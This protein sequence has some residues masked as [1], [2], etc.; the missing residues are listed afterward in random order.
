MRYQVSQPYKTIGKVM[1][2]YILMFMVLE[3][4]QEDKRL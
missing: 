1:I 2:L 4:R 3:M